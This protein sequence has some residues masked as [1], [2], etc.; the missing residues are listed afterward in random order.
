MSGQPRVVKVLVALLVS[1][2]A[3]AVVLMALG[4]NPPSAGPFCLAS[5]YRLDSVDHALHSQQPQSPYRWSAVEIFFSGTRGGNADRL[6]A[7]NN[8]SSAADLNCHFIVCNGVGAGD[9]EIESTER[10]QAQRSAQMEHPSPTGDRTIRIC[11]VGNGTSALPTDYQLR[12][13]EI[14]LEALCRRFNIPA[15]AVHIPRDCQ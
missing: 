10:W 1:M 15:S 4:S 3:G 13:L 6:A 2:T 11:L 9:G 5:Y 12:R 14:L 8:L 7:V